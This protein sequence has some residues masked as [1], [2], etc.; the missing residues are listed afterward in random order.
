MKKIISIL[1]VLAIVLGLSVTAF[2]AS[3]DRLDDQAN[4]MSETQQ[5][6]VAAKLDEVSAQLDADLVVVTVNDQI[7]AGKTM[8]EY[9]DDYYDSHLYAVDGVLLLINMQS[10]DGWFSSVGK[11]IYAFSTENMQECAEAMGPYLQ[12]RDYTGA[13]T[14]FA[15]KASEF[16]NE[17][18]NGE[19]VDIDGNG[20]GQYEPVDPYDPY[21]PRE[22][23]PATFG[24][25]LLTIIIAFV[26]A[27]LISL[28]IT[29]VMKGQM[30]SVISASDADQYVDPNQCHITGSR[31]RFLYHTV[32]VV[33]IPRQDNRQGPGGMGGGR[34]GG[35]GGGAPTH[36]SHSG[37]TH[38]GGGFKF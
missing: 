21:P 12:S 17:T 30:K 29:A 7:L 28:I 37:T 35:M 11:G 36:V 3:Y 9:A 5:Q 31:D 6:E 1:T 23:T 10:G 13:F 2:A 26:I 8:E 25:V 4:A 19:P 16:F 14:T 22:K 34:P 32:T 15:D 38:G 20:N 27:F 24:N 33:P 18:A